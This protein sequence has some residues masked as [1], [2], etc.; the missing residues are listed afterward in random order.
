MTQTAETTHAELLHWV[1]DGRLPDADELVLVEDQT[2]DEPW[3]GFYDGESWFMADGM[4]VDLNVI[5]WARWPA[6]TPGIT[7]MVPAAWQ[8]WC[9]LGEIKPIRPIF[10]EKE[11]AEDYAKEV[12]TYTE[13]RPL[14]SHASAAPPSAAAFASDH[15]GDANKMAQPAG[16]PLTTTQLRDALRNLRHVDSHLVE[17]HVSALVARWPA[18]DLATYLHQFRMASEYAHGPGLN[19]GHLAESC[20]TRLT[21][22]LTEPQLKRNWL[23]LVTFGIDGAQRTGATQADIIGHL[24]HMLTRF[25]NR[26]A[27]LSARD[28]YEQTDHT[29]RHTDVASR[30]V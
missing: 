22:A 5:A 2:S 4:P 8:V 1:T 14:W 20:L 30:E 28:P 13:V 23:D 25:R 29:A 19:T 11:V 10:L 12:K 3:A 17:A 9:G 24:E 7:K 6:G 27:D 18:F 21:R 15:F 26:A 16:E